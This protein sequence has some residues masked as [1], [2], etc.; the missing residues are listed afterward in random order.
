MKQMASATKL[1][2]VIF[3][4]VKKLGSWKVSFLKSSIALLSAEIPNDQL[5]FTA[6]C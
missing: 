6:A 5:G 4:V 2:L 3:R 1:S